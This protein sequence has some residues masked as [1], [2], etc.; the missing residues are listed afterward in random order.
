M[1]LEDPAYYAGPQRRIIYYQN[2]AD[3]ATLEYM[4]TYEHWSNELEKQR[5]Q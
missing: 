3:T 5:I 4:C 2:M 1:T